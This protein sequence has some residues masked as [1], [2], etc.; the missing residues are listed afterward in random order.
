VQLGLRLRELKAEK[1]DWRVKGKTVHLWFVAQ[2]FF[3]GSEDIK[4]DLPPL[5]IA[6]PF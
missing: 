6:D 2:T 3:A 5:D 4:L 1:M